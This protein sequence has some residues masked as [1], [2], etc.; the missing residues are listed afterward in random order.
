MHITYKYELYIYIYILYNIYLLRPT[1][2]HH[3]Y[4]EYYTKYEN[5]NF[6]IK[7]THLKE[8]TATYEES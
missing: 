4:I 7:D 8:G 3:Y 2:T 1:F 5:L 6:I